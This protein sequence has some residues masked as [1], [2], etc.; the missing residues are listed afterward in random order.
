MP[1]MQIEAYHRPADVDGAWAL[2]R[3]GGGAVRL[4]G[5]GTDIVVNCPPEVT[6]LVDLAD[7]GLRYVQANDDGG[8]AFGAMATFTDMLEHPAVADHATGVLT[9]MLSQVGSVLHRNS[10]TIGGHLARSRL[11]DVIPVL[12]ALDAT[13]VTYDGEHH[14]VGLEDYLDQDRGPHLVTEVRVPPTPA[15]AAAFV[16]FTRVAFDH[17]MVNGACRIDVDD[18][19]VVAARVVVGESAS[20]GRRVPAAEEALVGTPLDE[21]AIA[22]AAAAAREHVTMHGDWIASAEYRRHLAGVAVQR[23]LERAAERLDGGGP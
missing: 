12:I 17:S 3:D 23:C 7:A 2:L 6:T 14:E 11:S 21:A 20:V 4:V 18:G 5:G 9:E 19:E 15:G 8:L 13:V 1:L 16:R 22:A 10:A